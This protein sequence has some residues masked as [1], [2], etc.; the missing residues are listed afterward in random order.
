MAI[1][2]WPV[3]GLWLGERVG[4]VACEER[5]PGTSPPRIPVASRLGRF[6]VGAARVRLVPRRSEQETADG[7]EYPDRLQRRVR[8][9]Q[10]AGAPTARR[11]FSAALSTAIQSAREPIRSLSA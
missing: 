5:N 2:K 10:P 8:G 3:A 7:V 1:P 4:L 11:A 6:P 9:R